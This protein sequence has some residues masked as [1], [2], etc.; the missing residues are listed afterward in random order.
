MAVD[1]IFRSGNGNPL[2]SAQVDSN[3]KALK[4]AVEALQVAGSGVTSVGLSMPSG[5]AVANSPVTGAGTLAVTTT[6]NGFV[7][8]NGSGFTAAANVNAATEL[9]GVVPIANGGTNDNGSSYASNRVLV[10]NGTKFVT[11]ST[12]TTEV[13]YLSGV[14][15]SVQTQINGKENTITTLPINKGGTGLTATPTNGQLF[16]GNGSGYTLANI[17][18]SDGSVSVTNGAGSVNLTTAVNIDNTAFVAKNGN[19]ATATVNSVVNK[20]LTIGA[21]LAAAGADTVFVYAGTYTEDITL[22][23]GQKVYLQAGAIID[24]TVTMGNGT[25]YILGEGSIEKSS[26]GDAVLI[27]G[28][29]SSFNYIGCFQVIGG[30]NATGHAVRKTGSGYAEITPTCRAI[31]ARSGSDMAIDNQA[32]TMHIFCQFVQITGGT[33]ITTALIKNSATMLL[34]I[35]QFTTSETSATPALLIA[36][37]GS[38]RYYFNLCTG[39]V[40]VTGT[41]KNN[42]RAKGSTGAIKVNTGRY[43]INITTA[44]ATA[45]KVSNMN[46]AVVGYGGTDRGIRCSA[47]NQTVWIDGRVVSNVD[48]SKAPDPF[49]ITITGGTFTVNTALD[50][51]NP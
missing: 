21:A 40:E 12:T 16:I 24:G 8:G 6:L 43:P 38:S 35:D 1:I 5:F 28:N 39:F 44:S 13:N 31:Y 45:I 47:A 15:S 22:N 7:K 23:N 17:T 11:A 19:D 20:Y 51:T 34:D 9:T 37:S 33:S 42:I 4:V 46:L 50:T 2:S 41:G 10:Y 14:T 26:A 30:T 25:N 27:N 36:G 3:F 49:A 32:G 18:S 29:G 48:H